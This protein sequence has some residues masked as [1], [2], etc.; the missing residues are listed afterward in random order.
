MNK[1]NKDRD[2][3]ENNKK[4]DDD[5]NIIFN[6]ENW[7]NKYTKEFL[8]KYDNNDILI[9]LKG[10]DLSKLII[11]LLFQYD[12]IKTEKEQIIFSGGVRY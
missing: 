5:I 11:G 6:W 10:D 4:I 3:N 2:K 7:G 9:V 8:F 12:I 1:E